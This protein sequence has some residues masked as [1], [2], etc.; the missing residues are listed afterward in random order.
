MNKS[1]KSVGIIIVVLLIAAYMS[2][3]TIQQGREGL[4]L[5][6]GKLETDRQTGE[7]KIFMPGLHFKIP[8]LIS[9]FISP[10]I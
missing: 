8:F 4:L 2:I 10:G 6:L 7:P 3:F 9:Q 1:L 5:R